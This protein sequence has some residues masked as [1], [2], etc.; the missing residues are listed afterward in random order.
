MFDI[1]ME[2]FG[3]LGFLL[4]ATSITMSDIMKLR[5]YGAMGSFIFAIYGLH[6]AMYPVALVNSYLLIIN[7]YQI[8]KLLTIN[9]NR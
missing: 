2:L 6:S 4:L 3:Y 1:F 7:I 5:I 8:R 9:N